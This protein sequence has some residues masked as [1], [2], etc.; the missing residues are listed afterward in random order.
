MWIQNV[1]IGVTSEHA[2][3]CPSTQSRARFVLVA[4]IPPGCAIPL[5]LPRF[6]PVAAHC[7]RF[8]SYP[9]TVD[10]K[11]QAARLVAG[12]FLE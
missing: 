7:D 4:G 1:T 10:A 5:T 8:N 9:S 11:H 3:I 6:A 2:S 12:L